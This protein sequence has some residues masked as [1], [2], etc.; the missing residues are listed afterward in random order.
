MFDF[1]TLMIFFYVSAFVFPA[2]PW[3]FGARWGLRGVWLSTGLSI[4]I[5]LGFFP[6]LFWFGCDACGQ[7][8]IA[9]FILVPIWIISAFFTVVSAAAA[10]QKFKR[11]L[12]QD[13]EGAGR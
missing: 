4:V 1:G 12:P 5:L 11:S 3:L 6:V 7:G 13:H 9:I 10:H 2:V 8:A